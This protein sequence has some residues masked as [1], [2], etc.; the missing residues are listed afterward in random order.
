MKKKSAEMQ[1]FIAA[2]GSDLL[3]ALKED[4]LA[5]LLPHLRQKAVGKGM[6]LCEPGDP[7]EY[8]YFPCG[9]TLISF[10]VFLEDGRGI[11][12]VVIGR[13]GA[14]GGIVSQ[15]HL[16][17]YCQFLVQ[18]PGTVLY[19]SCADLQRAKEKS[20]TLNHFFAR[21][22]DCLLAQM[23]Q[24][25]A[26]NATHSIQ[27]RAAKWLAAARDRTG[28]NTMP[29]TQDNIADMLGVG[30]SYVAKVMGGLKSSGVLEVSRG[31]VTIRDAKKLKK[32][33]CDCD[34]LVRSHFTDV[35]AGSYAKK[36]TK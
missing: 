3:K 1:Q 35:L 6:V 30:R 32:I 2:G 36:S 7:V 18:F 24:A 25:V 17:A 23:F 13:E 4:D 27:Q 29:L 14:A 5:L 12:T 33:S 34:E 31:K 15:G 22:A 16:P 19:I 26:C 9:P 10:M 11:E 8:A 21:Y 28:D 20:P